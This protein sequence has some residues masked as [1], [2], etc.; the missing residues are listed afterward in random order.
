MYNFIENLKH[1]ET[2]K[3]YSPVEDREIQKN[4]ADSPIWKTAYHKDELE[5]AKTKHNQMF[6]YSIKFENTT[7]IQVTKVKKM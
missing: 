3:V 1:M 7:P 6:E 4:L 5:E 2:I